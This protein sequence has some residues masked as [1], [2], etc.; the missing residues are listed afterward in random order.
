MQPCFLHD[1][2][3][4]LFWNAT[5]A[6]KFLLNF[7]VHFALYGQDNFWKGIYVFLNVS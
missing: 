2:A 4:G 1:G 6:V 3:Y 7:E 5:K